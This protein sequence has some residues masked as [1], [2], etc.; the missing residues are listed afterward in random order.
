MYAASRQVTIVDAATAVLHLRMAKAGIQLQGFINLP[1][2]AVQGAESIDRSCMHTAL[3]WIHKVT[4]V[5]LQ[6]YRGD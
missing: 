4:A 2:K 3:D 6:P 5:F 1:L